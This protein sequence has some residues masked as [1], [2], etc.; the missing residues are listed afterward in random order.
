M[1]IFAKITIFS[2]I[3]FES[4]LLDRLRLLLAGPVYLKLTI[5]LLNPIGSY[6]ML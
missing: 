6:L 4:S 3:T 2:V 5:F 1:A